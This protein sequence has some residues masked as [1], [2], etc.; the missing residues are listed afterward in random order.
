MPR[1]W[2]LP[3]GYSSGHL[4]NVTPSRSLHKL[5]FKYS[6]ACWN[7]GNLKTTLRSAYGTAWFLLR[8]LHLVSRRYRTLFCIGIDG[9]G[10][11]YNTYS[12][13]TVWSA[14]I[15]SWNFPGTVVTQKANTCASLFTVHT[16]SSEFITS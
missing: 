4:A 13:E 11:R 15:Y 10:I 6:T 7:T 8:T 9:R 16:S 1:L 12:W 5:P 14:Y 2:H 3:T